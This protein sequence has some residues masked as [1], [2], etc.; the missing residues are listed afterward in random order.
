MVLVRVLHAYRARE[1]AADC[2]VRIL[3]E[4]QQRDQTAHSDGALEVKGV[5][6]NHVHA[7][8]NQRLGKL[9]AFF[10]PAHQNRDVA[11]ACAAGAHFRY[12]IQHR[13]HLVGSEADTHAPRLRLAAAGSLGHVGIHILQAH[14]RC[15]K[16]EKLAVEAHHLAGTAPVVPGVFH[17]CAGELPLHLPSE[18]APVRVAPSVYA[19]FDVAHD[20]IIPRG[21]GVPQQRQEI[22]PLQAG[23]ILELVEQEMGIASPRLLI[24]ERGVGTVYYLLQQAVGLVQRHHVLLFQQGVEFGFELPCHAEGVKLAV[25]DG[26]RGID[27]VFL[28]EEFRNLRVREGLLGGRILDSLPLWH[29]KAES[30]GLLL[31]GSHY[32][33]TL[34]PYSSKPLL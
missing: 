15:G 9:R 24:H 2:I 10:L 7:F 8:R 27:R 14:R 21:V 32:A 28:L 20:E 25:H 16:G 34:L 5:V 31:E 18:Q 6:G 3:I 26:G 11:G 30:S 4:G 17:A 12:R 33:G 22:V 13:L 29:G 1:V 23:G 19:L